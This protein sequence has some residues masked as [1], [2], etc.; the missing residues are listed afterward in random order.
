MKESN[1]LLL[2]IIIAIVSGITIGHFINEGLLRLFLTFNGIFSEFL[3]F[4]IPL[5]IIGLIIPS[6]GK[7]GHTASN[8]VI[9]VTILAYISTILSAYT[10]YGVSILTF[11]HL[12]EGQFLNS[13]NEIENIKPYFSLKFPPIIDVMSALLLAFIMGIGISKIQNSYLLKVCEEFE[14]I[15]SNVI[16]KI[17]IPALPLYIFGIFLSM[18]YTGEVFTII[19]IF[20]K[21]IAVIFG[22]HILYLVFLFVIAGTISKKN[23]FKLLITMMPAYFTALG[24]QSSAATIPV[25]LEQTIKNGV[26]EKVAKLTIPLCATIHLS[27]SALKIVACT[28]ALMIVQG[29]P[30]NFWD[31][32]GFILMLGIGMIAAPGVPG[33]AIMAAIGIIANMLGFDEKNQAL[34]ISLYIAMDNFG[35]A[36]N[37]TGDCAIAIITDS[38][39]KKKN[40]N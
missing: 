33:G 27:G 9:V 14:N 19:N 37:V 29:M 35:T 15:I 24:T 30:I 36:G 3:G 13:V 4:C 7:L 17:L 38:I 2:Q 6:I 31:Y 8:M 26:S 23:P 39:F 34:M 20:A 1:N 12:L 28:I 25:S 32:A 22:L 40:I 16:A 5:I 21:I 10:S 11:P 18:T